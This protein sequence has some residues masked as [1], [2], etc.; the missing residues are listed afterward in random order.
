MSDRLSEDEERIRRELADLDCLL[1]QASISTVGSK[2][3]GSRGQAGR[4]GSRNSA[5]RG[6]GVGGQASAGP[7]GMKAARAKAKAV[8]NTVLAVNKMN[9][10][11]RVA[12]VATNATRAT[13]ASGRT[14]TISNSAEN[15]PYDPME[16]LMQ[17]ARAASEKPETPEPTSDEDDKRPTSPRP[18]S[19][20][21]EKWNPPPCRSTRL[22]QQPQPFISA[23]E[24]WK[25]WLKCSAETDAGQEQRIAS[26]EYWAKRKK[27]PSPDGHFAALASSGRNAPK[28]PREGSVFLSQTPE[29]Q[30]LASSVCMHE[31]TV[32]EKLEAEFAKAIADIQ[33]P[34]HRVSVE[35]SGSRPPVR[36]FHNV[37]RD[38]K[39]HATY[40]DH[41]LS[42]NGNS[43][44]H[45]VRLDEFN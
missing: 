13:N 43:S 15:V 27:S 18:G 28:S 29:Q 41:N 37:L 16:A 10:P 22:E 2:P 26:V 31:H 5:G 3:P 35:D 8:A 36:G 30:M 14:V 11:P 23:D 6:R 45:T 19:P 42:V 20:R 24:G 1:E 9:P 7:P 21:G 40:V 44:V 39:P 17:V 25:R 12:P 34:C 33:L 32:I 38:V 4:N